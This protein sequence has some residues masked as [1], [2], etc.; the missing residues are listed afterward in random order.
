MRE[1]S[2][3]EIVSHRLARNGLSVPFSQ[4]LECVH[5]LAG[6]QSQFQQWAEV[7]IRNRSAAG[8]TMHDLA[9][10]YQGHDILNLW[11]RRHTLHMYAKKDWD[12][13]SHLYE[14]VISGKS[15]ASTRFPD[16]FDYLMKKI[17]AECSGKHTIGKA[18]LLAIVEE[19]MAGRRTENDYFDY[20]LIA[21]CCLRGIF[22]GIPEKPGL[23][24][25]AGRKRV[26]LKPWKA[27]EKHSRAALESYMLRYFQYYGPATL[28][29]F[30]H[31]SGLPQGTA[32]QGLLSVS[33]KLETYVSGGREYFSHGQAAE[34]DAGEVF[35]LGKFDPLFVSYKHKDWIIPAELQKRVWRS[36]GWVEAVVLDRGLAMGTW[37]HSLKGKKISFEVSQFTTIKAASRK[38][39]KAEAEKLADF[40]EKQLASV[41][42]A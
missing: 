8:L 36:A 22:C 3:Q 6:I 23:K 21:L 1:I 37:R 12:T 25:F 29:D 4:P 38:K 5:A 18:D 19:R 24:T 2:A 28:A 26:A 27:N 39:V 11:G 10:F 14:P 40:W 41:T 15:R 13:V 42:F 20:S 31:W 32:R 30:S 9:A 7:S 17:A 34:P 16:D 35:L 33:E